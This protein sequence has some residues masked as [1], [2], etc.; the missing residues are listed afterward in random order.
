MEVHTVH[1]VP[2]VCPRAHLSGS[3]SDS[4]RR[5]VGETPGKTGRGQ[6]GYEE[7]SWVQIPEMKPAKARACGW[8][9][10]RDRRVWTLS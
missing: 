3:S 6:L 8:C 2:E 9:C 1:G 4:K 7:I 10:I 5:S